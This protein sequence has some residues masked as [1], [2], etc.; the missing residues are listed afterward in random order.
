M[1]FAKPAIANPVWLALLGACAPA[2]PPAHAQGVPAPVAG[3]ARCLPGRYKGFEPSVAADPKGRVLVAAI[4]YRWNK[5]KKEV[6]SPI[7][8]IAWRSGDRGVTW[9]EPRP[10]GDDQMG[11]VWLQADPRG[12]FLAAHLQAH[13]SLDANPNLMAVFRR[14]EGGGETWKEARV[15]GPK[16]DKTV[17]AVSPS[18]SRL[19]VAFHAV[20]K[21]QPAVLRSD[22]RGEHW[23]AI[24]RAG[25]RE[26][27][28]FPWGLGVNDDGAVVAA[29]M[30]GE[31]DFDSRSSDLEAAQV[32][33]VVS[34]TNDAG[35]TWKDLELASFTPSQLEPGIRG[36]GS[37]IGRGPGLA[38]ALDGSGTAHAVYC[39]PAGNKK[40]YRLLYRRSA[41]LRAWSGPVPLS[42]GDADDFR[43]FP[44][45]AAAGDRVHVAWMDR[46]GG[47]YNVWYRASADGGK[48]WSKPVRLSRPGRPTGLLTAD[49]F[50][51]PAGHYMGLTEDGKGTAHAAWGVGGAGGGEVWHCAVRPRPA[52]RPAK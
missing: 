50:K 25:P 52:E 20:N 49:G 17:L 41:D 18:G 19:A 26:W 1:P 28:S 40:D 3:P 51:E 33:L 27:S 6:S 43:G 14:S 10:M 24:P 7:Y 30:L 46:S 5:S 8:L 31:R 48:T 29:W 42:P 11:D 36:A 12:G 44:A 35:K 45:V 21:R 15:L 13:G 16:A 23:R 4:D 38:L 34:T 37:G 9:G 2:S 39:Y 32:K 22:D 47:L